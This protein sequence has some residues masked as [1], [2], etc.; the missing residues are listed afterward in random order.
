MSR[1]PMG[2]VPL[3]VLLADWSTIACETGLALLPLLLG[4][5]VCPGCAAP[6]TPASPSA[7]GFCILL[8]GA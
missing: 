4:L 5:P 6:G 7:I 2:V 8:A 1:V 3:L